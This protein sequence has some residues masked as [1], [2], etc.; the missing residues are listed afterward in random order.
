MDKLL[1]A[2]KANVRK[3]IRV[4]ARMLNTATGGTLHP[5]AVTCFGLLMHLPI[6]YFIAQGE[7]VFAA[8]LLVVFGLFDA[9]DG[10]LARLQKRASNTGM[11]LDSIT[12]RMKEVILYGGI[13]SYLLSQGADT[14]AIWAIFA[15]GGSMLTSYINAWGDVVM[16]KAGARNHK[17]NEGFRGGL[18]RFE[19]RMFL[20]V[21]ALF[22][23]QLRVF[24]VVI[25]ILAWFTAFQRLALIIRKLGHV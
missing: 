14:S 23:N 6:A 7:L 18:M 21:V 17:A 12:D 19:V 11:L 3:P 15:L 24:V 5:N 9:L 4:F 1:D 22:A 25:A 10:E 16:S 2:V 13:V 20:L 8:I